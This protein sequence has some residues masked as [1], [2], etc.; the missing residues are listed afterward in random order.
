MGAIRVR[1]LAT[2]PAGRAF[3]ANWLPWEAAEGVRGRRG[4]EDVDARL[5]RAGHLFRFQL[6]LRIKVVAHETIERETPRL[7]R[8]G[9]QAA[10]LASDDRKKHVTDEEHRRL[11]GALRRFT[12]SRVSL[13]MAQRSARAI[14]EAR[15]LD[16]RAVLFPDDAARWPELVREVKE[17]AGHDLPP[18]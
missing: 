7:R 13:L 1:R 16:G 8:I 3:L 6:V 12:A 14:A 10:A 2:R 5:G 4:R 18:R 9:R 15:H 17:L 11:L